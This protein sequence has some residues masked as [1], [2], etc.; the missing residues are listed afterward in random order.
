MARRTTGP[1]QPTTADAAVRVE[2]MSWGAA[3]P[4]IDVEATGIPAAD[5]VPSI[6]RT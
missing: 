6:L 1:R 4:E 2:A 3:I 5:C